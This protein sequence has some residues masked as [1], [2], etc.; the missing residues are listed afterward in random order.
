[1]PALEQLCTYIKLLFV[2]VEYLKRAHRQ[3]TNVALIEE[4]GK[5]MHITVPAYQQLHEHCLAQHLHLLRKA[6][7]LQ[8]CTKSLHDMICETDRSASRQAWQLNDLSRPSDVMSPYK[9][10]SGS[11]V[12]GSNPRSGSPV[13]ASNPRTAL[14]LG[15]TGDESGLQQRIKR[16]VSITKLYL[17]PSSQ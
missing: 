17:S 3:S 8:P 7:I 10:N 15:T 1:M 5:V 6:R 14:R 13:R 12:K 2:G 11:P 9:R 4:A 16:S